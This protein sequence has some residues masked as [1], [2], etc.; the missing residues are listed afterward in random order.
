MT[1]AAQN[2]S[3][4]TAA[5]RLAE[6]A[7]SYMPL[8]GIPDE[9]IGEDGRPRAHWLRFLKSLTEL[10]SEEI[11]K[12][13]ATADRHIRETGVTYRA[14]GDTSERA[15][16]LSHMPLLISAAEWQLIARGIEQRARLLELV[17]ADIYGEGKLISSGDI[18]AAVVTGSPDF[19]HPLKGV[20]P[21]GGKFLHLY[22]ADIGRGPDGSWWVIG[23]RT[24]A[25]SGAGYALANR[26]V[27]SR[28]FPSLYRNMNVE[29]LAPFFQ[30]FRAGLTGMGQRLRAG[31]SRAL[32]WF[33][34]G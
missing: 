33:S 15:W 28:A 26:L 34:A 16:P 4:K 31:L 1:S 7:D 25:P 32:S 29:R 14:Y 22:A 5:A 11:A 6:L 2:L 13:F 17:A 3:P 27:L 18:P 21:Q 30:A 19:L 8:A 23:D 9:F 20:K 24:Q 12:R 10:D